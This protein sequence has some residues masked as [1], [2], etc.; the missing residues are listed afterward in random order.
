MEKLIL[1]S[2]VIVAIALPGWLSTAPKPQKALR[3]MQG[4]LVVFVVI[5]GYL[6]TH[7]YP[8]LVPLK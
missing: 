4:L 1:L 5:W 3:K 8:A 6:C 2:I 7:W